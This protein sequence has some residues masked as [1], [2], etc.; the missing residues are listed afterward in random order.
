MS[1]VKEMISHSP[2]SP[3]PILLIA[4]AFALPHG[5]IA[6]SA[7]NPSVQMPED[8]AKKLTSLR[9]L[10][11]FLLQRMGEKCGGEGGLLIDDESKLPT[12]LPI[13]DTDI[14]ANP[15]FMLS[16]HQQQHG[17]SRAADTEVLPSASDHSDQPSDGDRS[18]YEQSPDISFSFE[19]YTKW[20]PKLIYYYFDPSVNYYARVQ[21]ERAID[22]LMEKSCLNMRR[23]YSYQKGNLIIFTKLYLGNFA[24]IGRQPD[25]NIINLDHYN[26]YS[27]TTILHEILHSLGR[28][29]EH[30][31]SDRDDYVYVDF[32]SIGQGFDDQF[33]LRPMASLSYGVE[34]DFS[35]IMHYPGDAFSATWGSESKT[36]IAH[37]SR[38]QS[39]MGQS[40]SITYM[41][42]LMLN[43]A[44]CPIVESERP[45]S[46]F[47]VDVD[48]FRA[49][50]DG[51]DV[52]HSN[53]E[54]S[55]PS[56]KATQSCFN[57][58]FLKTPLATRCICPESFEGEKCQSLR[59][60]AACPTQY[61]DIV[62]GEEG[63]GAR[64]GVVRI[65]HD[66]SS[67]SAS[68][69]AWW[70]S[71]SATYATQ[72]NKHCTWRITAPAGRKIRVSVVGS[73]TRIPCRSGLYCVQD[74]LEIRRG[75]GGVRNGQKL[76]CVRS[77][78]TEVAVVEDEVLL[79]FRSNSYLS[80]SVHVIAELV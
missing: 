53:S 68:S 20:D 45:S 16:Q 73:E 27:E 18:G 51:D 21:I 25:F 48:T 40:A 67:S 34:Y 55:N 19:G 28:V 50:V 71:S 69:S 36:I 17:F 79:L 49:H 4:V 9:I 39:S 23:T 74:W 58:G 78:T 65:R 2:I 1:P 46:A 30:M 11:C 31:R 15:T 80:M 66:T 5:W 33:Y 42:L 24:S 43:R 6:P 7:D 41:D 76:C 61:A 70:T 22:E 54:D 13:F 63:D 72:R 59:N 62:L 57:G 52:S 35:S 12:K 32:T 8:S 64:G 26:R 38:F 29:H 10:Q 77:G 14:L 75:G 56:I 47:P 44:Y 60:D 3:I 37:D